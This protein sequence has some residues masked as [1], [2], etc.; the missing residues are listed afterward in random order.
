M[1]VF[2]MHILDVFVIKIIFEGLTSTVAFSLDPA[3][4]FIHHMYPSV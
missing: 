2:E 4:L 1:K 3:L